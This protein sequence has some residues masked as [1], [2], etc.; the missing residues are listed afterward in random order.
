MPETDQHYVPQLLLRGF[1]H[2][3]RKQLY[4]F[5]KRTG[6]IFRSSVRNLACERGFYGFTDKSPNSQSIDD[7]IEIAE[8]QAAPPLERI[9]QKRTLAC[10]NEGEREWIAALVA[11]QILRTPAS[12]ENQ[13]HI[14][15][16]MAFALER[17]GADL[18]DIKNFRP[19]GDSE[20]RDASIAMLPGVTRAVYPQLSNKDWVLMEAKETLWISDNPV[21]KTNSFNPGDGLTSTHGLAVKGI[22]IYI[23]LSDS[24]VLAM[25]C[26]TIRQFF[27][28][29]TM[30]LGNQDSMGNVT[31]L[32]SAFYHQ[33]L[34]QCVRQNVEFLNSSQVAAAERYVYSPHNDFQL[35][36]RMIALNPDLRFGQRVE[37][38]HPSITKGAL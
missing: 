11:V 38:H 31:E 28:A 7:W 2:G 9:R 18:N 20:L 24:L 13:A 14:H 23:P 37:V 29:A 25:F 15:K 12:R 22:E 5:D 33:S 35:A 34:I 21:I 32:K 8:S 19:M 4:C 16:S 30:P 6:R 36:E 1:A 17:M 27:D 26:P 10:I 3:K